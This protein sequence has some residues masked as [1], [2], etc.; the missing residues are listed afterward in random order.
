MTLA[1]LAAGRRT[2]ADPVG[3]VLALG[4]LTVVMVLLSPVCHLHYFVLAVPLIL[5][6]IFAEWQRQ[7]VP[8]VGWQLA[9]VLGLYLAGGTL[10]MLPVVERYRDFG[11]AAF[12]TLI[13]W[14]A[15]V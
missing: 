6:L 13:V 9:L 8:Q 5:G 10:P 15:G 1:T 7:G 14:L 12:G 4:L 11:P 3:T 2:T